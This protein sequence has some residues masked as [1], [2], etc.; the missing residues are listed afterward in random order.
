MSTKIKQDIST[1]IK[2]DISAKIKQDMSTKIKQDRSTKIK[3]YIRSYDYDLPDEPSLENVD[4][5]SIDTEAMG[6][7]VE[8]DRLCMVQIYINGVIYLIHFPEPI[9]N[10]S[11]KLKKLLK[12]QRLKKY[13]HYAFFDLAMILKYLNVLLKNVIC[14]RTASR[15]CRT[16]A[17]SHGLK[18]V[19]RVFLNREI[20]KECQ[21]SYWGTDQ[22][23]HQQRNYAAQDV[24]YLHHLYPLMEKQLKR[25]NRLKVFMAM[26]KILPNAVLVSNSGFDAGELLN[27]H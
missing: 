10:K 11:P 18:G 24:M 21:S 19:C 17:N 23:T 14:T 22:L 27:H 13:M 12:N 15:I 20:N 3:Q 5:I 8:R 2:Q 4:A 1:K 7:K 16:Y 6:L 26:M 25:E 9:Y